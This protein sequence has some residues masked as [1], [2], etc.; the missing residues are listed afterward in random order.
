MSG[1][2]RACARKG[3]GHMSYTFCEHRKCPCSPRHPPRRIIGRGNAQGEDLGLFKP[4]QAVCGALRV[5][6]HRLTPRQSEGTRKVNTTT[7]NKHIVQRQMA[8]E[9]DEC[10]Q[11]HAHNSL[12]FP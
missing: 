9:L 2:A 1:L 3:K 10:C 6:T 7:T 5:H 8:R 4:Y 12:I 11:V